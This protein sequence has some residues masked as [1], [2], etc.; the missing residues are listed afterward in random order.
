MF[1]DFQDLYSDPIHEKLFPFYRNLETA[2][3]LYFESSESC[4]HLYMDKVITAHIA[5]KGARSVLEEPG[6]KKI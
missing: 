1:S 6:E 4:K 5:L 3:D 2:V